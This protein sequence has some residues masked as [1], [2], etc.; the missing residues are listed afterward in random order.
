MSHLLDHC[1]TIRSW[2]TQSFVKPH[3]WSCHPP[4]CHYSS[5]SW[6]LD[7]FVVIFPLYIITPIFLSFFWSNDSELL[8][9]LLIAWLVNHH[10]SWP[11][12]VYGVVTIVWF[13][14]QLC[15]L[16]TL[17]HPSQSSVLLWTS[18]LSIL[19]APSIW[20]ALLHSRLS[21]KLSIALLGFAPPPA[22]PR[23]AFIVLST[24][25]VEDT[26]QKQDP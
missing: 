26:Q 21:L 18:Q 9:S 11:L 6:T 8:F 5:F 3:S 15:N 14:P 19:R 16:R 23:I 24:R 17:L 4:I 25:S 20:F 7:P 2:S 1:H 10:M 12:K 13:T 22:Q